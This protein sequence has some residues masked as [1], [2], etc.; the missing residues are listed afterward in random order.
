MSWHF[1]LPASPE[2]LNQG[3]GYTFK[4][5]IVIKLA[6]LEIN[7]E[8]TPGTECATQSADANKKNASYITIFLFDNSKV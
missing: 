1:S 7:L 3:K 8:S 4:T 2:V 5:K 6:E